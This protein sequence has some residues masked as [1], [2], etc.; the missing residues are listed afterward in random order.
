MSDAKPKI[1]RYTLQKAIE[2]D[3]KAAI[4]KAET[5]FALEGSDTDAQRRFFRAIVTLAAQRLFDLGIPAPIIA[6]QAF[7]AVVH[8]RDHRAKQ[9]LNLNQPFGLQL[10]AKA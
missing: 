1:S 6:Q 8:E 5:Q 3:L 9:A 10:P 7:E 2:A 4:T